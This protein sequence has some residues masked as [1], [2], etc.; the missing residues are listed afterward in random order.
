MFNSANE[1]I[2][3]YFQYMKDDELVELL[4]QLKKQKNINISILVPVSAL[5]DEN[6]KKL[7]QSGINIK[8]VSEYKMHAKA[9]LIDNKYLFI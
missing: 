6:T 9:I 8:V 4:M 3:I 2:K 1:S 7:K 5:D